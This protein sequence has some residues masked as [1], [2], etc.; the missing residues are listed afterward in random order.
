LWRRELSYTFT[1][2]TMTK[3]NLK[4]MSLLRIGEKV[5]WQV[6]RVTSIGVVLDD[7]VEGDKTVK[8]LTHSIGGMVSHREVEVERELL[9]LY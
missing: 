9:K 1:E 2:S 3:I 6:G 5:Q 8:I 4:V 7:E